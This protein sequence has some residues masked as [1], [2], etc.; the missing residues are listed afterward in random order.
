MNHNKQKFKWPDG[1]VAAVSL[2]YEDGL[3]SQLINAIPQLDK[4]GFKGTFFP[5][6]NGLSNPEFINNWKKAV[7]NGHE[8]GCHTVFHPCSDSFDFVKIN[9]TE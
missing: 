9:N 5:S 3:E 4:F 6:T 1:K 2:T 7:L 8:I